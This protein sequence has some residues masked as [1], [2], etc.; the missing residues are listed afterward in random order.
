MKSINKYIAIIITVFLLFGIVT[1]NPDQKAKADELEDLQSTIDSLVAQQASIA[2][3]KSQAEA[4]ILALEEG[5]ATSESNLAWLNERSQ[6]Q[7]EAYLSLKERQDVVLDMLNTALNNLE[8][9]QNNFENKKEQYGERIATMFGMQHKSVIELLL[10]ADS[11]EGFFTSVK[12]MRIITDED[13]AALEGLKKDQHDLEVLTEQT[14]SN[15]NANQEELAEI[16]SILTELQENIDFEVSEITYYND[17]IA[18]KSGELD[19]Y[20][21]LESE[22]QSALSAAN[23]NY[24]AIEAEREA[25]RIAAEEEQRRQAEAAEQE[26]IA[27][28][29]RQE[30]EAAGE[31]TNPAPI[32][33]DTGDSGYNEPSYSGGALVWPVPSSHYVSSLYGYRSFM[34]NGAPYSDFHT[35]MDISAPSGSAFVA[36]AAGVI[37]Y[38]GWVNVGGNAVIID[39]GNGFQTFGCHLSGFN[40]GVGQQVAAGETVAFVGSTGF[41]T[42]PHLHF[43]VRINGSS[44][45][46]AGYLY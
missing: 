35:G 45:D 38:A 20:A 11:L 2:E 24:A 18:D 31:I 7:Q 13:E 36:P 39:H 30:Q 34:L 8:V 32:E 28:E 43:E 33:P 5:K 37:T 15:V 1:I 46:P 41:S 21:A 3:Q 14:Q 27:E 22:V 6:E 26:R 29:Q 25:A 19:T 23:A 42:G 4:D 10:E 44:V 40:V 16:E 12:F 9:A 17:S